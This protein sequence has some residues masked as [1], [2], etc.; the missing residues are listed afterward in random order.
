MNWKA[1]ML[2]LFVLIVSASFQSEN[3]NNNSESAWIK[4]IVNR[5]DV[6]E[7]FLTTDK[8]ND[9]YITGYFISKADFGSRE[10]VSVGNYDIFLAKYSHTGQLLWLKQAGGDQ[11]DLAKVIQTDNLGNVYVTGYISGLALFDSYIVKSKGTFDIFTAKYNG[12]GDLQWIKCEGAQIVCEPNDIKRNKLI[13][14]MS[15]K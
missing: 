15:R 10:L 9:L 7:Y 6:T 4:D 8:F 11:A 1:I 2:M 3:P 14:K 13:A 12:D 5:L